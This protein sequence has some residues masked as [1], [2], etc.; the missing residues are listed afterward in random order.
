VEDLV[1]QA[2]AALVVV[3]VA[4][5]FARPFLLLCFDPEQAEVAGFS[6]RRYH[7]LMLLLVAMTV[8]VSF[9]TV[10]TLLVFGMLLA[11]SSTG[12]LIASR[13]EAMMAWAAVFGAGSVYL[14]LL[15]SY[16]LNFA[17]GA[18]IVFVATVAFF[19]VLVAVNVRERGLPRREALE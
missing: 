2:V 19:V 18:S 5:A 6:E 4:I 3:V 16:H 11:P 7:A 17:A 12:A 9:Q 1:V 10:G 14:G 8:I 15:L 13:I